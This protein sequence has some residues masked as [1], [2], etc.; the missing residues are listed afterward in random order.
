MQALKKRVDGGEQPYISAGLFKIRIPFIH[1]GW[2]WTEAIQGLFMVATPMSAATLAMQVLEIPFELAIM[3]VLTNNL[4]YLMHPILGDPVFPGWITP[5]MA[6]VVAYLM[7]YENLTDRIHALVALQLVIAAIFLIFGIS[8]LAAKLMSIIPASMRGGILLGAGISSIISCIEKQL[9]GHEVSLAVGISV[10]LLF[11]YSVRLA[12]VKSK[13]AALMN[14]S[15]FG[16]IIGLGCAYVVGLIIGD[17]TPPGNLLANGWFTTYSRYGEAFNS[18][19]VFAVGFPAASFFIAGIPMAITDYIIAFGD[20][21]YS[22]VLIGTSV[23]QRGDEYVDFN[24]SRSNVICGIRNII[25]GLFFPYPPILGP[26]WGAGVTSVAE[27][28]KHGRWQMDSIFDGLIPY[29]GCMC[30]GL[31]IRPVVTLFQPVLFLG[32]G[33]TLA[34][35]GFASLY[36]AMDLLPSEEERGCGGIM[37]VF[38]AVKGASWGLGCGIL[39]H[40]LIG[41]TDERKAANKARALAAQKTYE[42]AVARSKADAARARAER[43]AKKA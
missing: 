5:G 23:T 25:M 6:L 7:T 40:L 34:V 35:Q 2:E 17:V 32:M 16:L 42:E 39:L 31:I 14:V 13:S 3:W 37:A 36:I 1:T 24:P 26:L 28:Y 22:E 29:I 10:S 33:L 12:K 4:L 27:R 43:K 21:V 15:K 9:T 19:T 38:L 20:F 11:M 18:V 41:V 30:I 8:G